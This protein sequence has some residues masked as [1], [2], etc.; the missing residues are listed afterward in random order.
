MCFMVHYNEKCSEY[1]EKLVQQGI[2]VKFILFPRLFR[3]IEI[4]LKDSA[5]FVYVTAGCLINSFY[6]NQMRFDS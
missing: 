2:D 5:A 3:Q 4:V 6:L 1:G